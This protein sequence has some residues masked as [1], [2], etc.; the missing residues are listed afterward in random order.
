MLWMMLGSGEAQAHCLAAL[1]VQY[2][3][4]IHARDRTLLF[5]TS[6]AQ[7]LLGVLTNSFLALSAA[8]AL[9]LMGSLQ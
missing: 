7:T 8:E 2:P 3:L 1:L 6:Y 9:I 4:L 5:C